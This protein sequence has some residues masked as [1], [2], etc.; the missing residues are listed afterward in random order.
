MKEEP[1]NMNTS[2]RAQEQSGARP[3]W[4]TV[5]LVAA[6][7]AAVF[8]LLAVVRWQ[9]SGDRATAPVV[10]PISATTPSAPGFGAGG[11]PAGTDIPGAIAEQNVQRSSSARPECETVAYPTTC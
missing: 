5:L 6:G 10:A 9:D 7:F 1:M 11:A 2:I 4:S 8:L 3:W